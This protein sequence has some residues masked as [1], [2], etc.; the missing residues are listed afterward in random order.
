PSSITHQHIHSFPTRR[1][2]DL[3]KQQ[4]ERALRFCTA[5]SWFWAIR[6][7]LREGQH[8]LE[9]AL[10]LREKVSVPM[11]ARVLYTAADLGWILDDLDRK[12]TRLNSS[13][14]TISYA[15]F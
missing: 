10:A 1:S 2:S 14:R 4:A 12:S 3:N 7:Y 9:Q 13:H 8:F 15:V 5:L 6:G 11:R